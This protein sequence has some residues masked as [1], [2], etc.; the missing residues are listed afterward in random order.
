MN[1]F[2][3]YL[4]FPVV[5]LEITMA[6]M[7]FSM[8]AVKKVRENM[9]LTA[10]SDSSKKWQGNNNAKYNNFPADQCRVLEFNYC[11]LH[12]LFTFIYF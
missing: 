1:F 12:Y 2:N 4:L 7:P 11:Q 3:F 10:N 6:S 8:H 9:S 5:Y